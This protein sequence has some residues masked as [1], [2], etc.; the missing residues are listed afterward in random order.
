VKDEVINKMALAHN[1]LV[2]ATCQSI[3]LGLAWIFVLTRLYIRKFMV[4]GVSLDDYFLILTVVSFTSQTQTW[5]LYAETLQSLYSIF[6]AAISV[7]ASIYVFNHPVTVEVFEASLD[8][9]SRGVHYYYLA[10]VFYVIT[11]AFLRVTVSYS[12]AAISFLRQFHKL[13]LM[14]HVSSVEH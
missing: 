5:N 9:V 11:A 3:F 12:L 13:G 4:H 10:E 2:I 6:A 14:N 8:K 1:A 7:T